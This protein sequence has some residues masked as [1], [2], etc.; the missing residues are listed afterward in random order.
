MILKTVPQVVVRSPAVV[1]KRL[2]SAPR[3]R[4]AKGWEP[5]VLSKLCCVVSVS[6]GAHLENSAEAV[7]PA[8]L[9][10]AVEG[11]VGQLDEGRER[12]GPVGAD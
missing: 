10:R 1:P 5:S 9:R 2:P 6:R 7:H 12:N 4:A 3:T 11:A 8:V